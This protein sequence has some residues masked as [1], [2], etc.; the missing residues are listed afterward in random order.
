MKKGFTSASLQAIRP[1]Q[2]ME[3]RLQALFGPKA[4]TV[5]SEESRHKKLGCLSL[6]GKQLRRSIAAASVAIALLP[7]TSFAQTQNLTANQVRGVAT[8]ALDAGDFRLAAAASNALLS[9]IPDDPTA[10]LVRTEV[11]IV[12]RD[13]EGAVG[14][15]Q[16]AFLNAISDEQ[17]F[18]AARLIA[19]AHANAEQFSRSQVWLR[20]ARQFAPNDAAANAVAQDFR[21]VR[22]QNPLSVDLRFGITPSTNVNS[23][24]SNDFISLSGLPFDISEDGEALSGWEITA[25]SNLSYR[26]RTDA[27]SVTF[28]TFDANARAVRFTQS[29]RD[30][31]NND[32]GSELTEGDLSSTSASIG[33]NHR[34]VLAP[35]VGLTTAGLS[36]TQNWSGGDRSR[37]FLTT[38]LS[39]TYT[40]PNTDRLTLSGF[41]QQQERLETNERAQVFD[42]FVNYSRNFEEFGNV[43]FGL[44]LR[45][46]AA[47][48][49]R[50]DFDSVRYNLSFNPADAFYGINFGFSLSYEERDF[51]VDLINDSG[52][53]DE[54][55]TLRARAVFSDV[56]FFGFQP[57]VT[58]ERSSQESTS[59][60][61]DRD[62]TSIGFD[63][64]SAF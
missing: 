30:R 64:V 48:D 28:L 47:E 41:S 49:P 62:F 15:G 23:G 32:E 25:R 9:Q 20:A 39:H 6:I 14:F 21:T 12:V 61:F 51:A 33:V 8:A 56:E 44:G 18:T 45:D 2:Q 60:L 7:S 35:D 11:A 1:R 37:R 53:N 31:I 50:E 58:A 16:R 36:F 63:I 57:V 27:T 46:N 5:D 38:S 17:R 42:L 40:L 19:V 52:R 26:I 34:F 3:A 54:I 10:L 24:T 59:A 13:N 22:N 29:S 4:Q 55:I 43:S